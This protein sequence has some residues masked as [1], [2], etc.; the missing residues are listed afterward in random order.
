MQS[1]V[2]KLLTNFQA[3]LQ[4]TTSLDEE[5]RSLIMKLSP[6]YI[7]WEQEALRKGEEQ[8]L[9]QARYTARTTARKASNN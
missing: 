1:L 6:L 7:Q 4:T 3:N 2:L 5:E 8:G 9:Q